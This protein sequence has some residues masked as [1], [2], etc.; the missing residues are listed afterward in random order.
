MARRHAWESSAGSVWSSEGSRETTL[1]QHYIEASSVSP[2]QRHPWELPLYAADDETRAAEHAERRQLSRLSVENKD[3]R[4]RLAS[5]HARVDELQAEV[6]RLREEARTRGLLLTQSVS[7]SRGDNNDGRKRTAEE[8]ALIHSLALEHKAEMQALQDES[9]ARHRKLTEMLAKENQDGHLDGLRTNIQLK[10]RLDELVERTNEQ[11]RLLQVSPRRNDGTGSKVSWSLPRDEGEAQRQTTALQYADEAS[12]KKAEKKRPSSSSSSSSDST[13]D[14]KKQAASELSYG[15]TEGG[16]VNRRPT[17][18]APVQVLTPAIAWHDKRGDA[19]GDPPRKIKA[20][21]KKKEKR[22][23]PSSSSSSPSPQSSPQHRAGEEQAPARGQV[24]TWHVPP[25]RRVSEEYHEIVIDY[26]NKASPTSKQQPT[27][28][29]YVEP[30]SVIDM[31]N[32]N[33]KKDKREEKKRDSS[34]SSSPSSSASSPSRATPSPRAGASE[35]VQIWHVPPP[36]RVSE[37][38]PEGAIAYGER[39]KTPKSEQTPTDAWYK[40]GNQEE[41]KKKK[42]NKEKKDKKEKKRSASSSS[43]SSSSSHRKTSSAGRVKAPPPGIPEPRV[44]AQRPTVVAAGHTFNS[45][46]RRDASDQKGAGRPGRAPEEPAHPSRKRDSSR[47][48]SSSSSSSSASSRRKLKG[49]AREKVPPGA[50]ALEQRPAVVAAG[51]TYKSAPLHDG[52]RPTTGCASEATGHP[53]HEQVLPPAVVLAGNRYKS[54]PRS[55]AEDAGPPSPGSPYASQR[56]EKRKSSLKPASTKFPVN[57]PTHGPAAPSREHVLTPK[58]PASS[59]SSSSSSS[60]SSRRRK[61]ASSGT[62]KTNE[63]TPAVGWHSSPVEGSVKGFRPHVL[64]TPAA[65]GAAAP[66]KKKGRTRASSASSS[67]S[68]SSSSSPPR[69]ASSTRPG[70]SVGIS[71]GGAKVGTTSKGDMPPAPFVQEENMHQYTTGQSQSFKKRESI[72]TDQSR[73]KKKKK[74]KKKDRKQSSSSSSSS[75]ASSSSSPLSPR[76]RDPSAPNGGR[77]ESRVPPTSDG[78]A[79]S[80]QMPELHSDGRGR[81]SEEGT[82]QWNGAWGGAE[83]ASA[84]PTDAHRKDWEDTGPVLHRESTPVWVA[85]RE[86]ENRADTPKKLSSSSSSSSSPSSTGKSNGGTKP[87]RAHKQRGAPNTTP[88]AQPPRAAQPQGY[89]RSGFSTPLPK[90]AV[91]PA[92][93]HGVRAEW[94]NKNS[95]PF[96]TH[97]SSSQ[98]TSTEVAQPRVPAEHRQSQYS[99]VGFGPSNNSPSPANDQT[100]FPWALADTGGKEKGVAHVLVPYVVTSHD[101]DLA[102][103]HAG[104]EQQPPTP[105]STPFHSRALGPGH[106]SESPSYGAHPARRRAAQTPVEPGR[107]GRRP[108]PDGRAAPRPITGAGLPELQLPHLTQYAA[109]DR[110]DAEDVAGRRNFSPI[111]STPPEPPL[112]SSSLLGPA[113][114]SSS[115]T[116]SGPA[117]RAG[118]Q[119]HHP[120]TT[121]SISPDG[122]FPVGS[123]H[124]TSPVMAGTRSVSNGF[125]YASGPTSRRSPPQVHFTQHD[126]P[127]V[128]RGYSG[129]KQMPQL[130]VRGTRV[131][132][133]AACWKWGDQDGGDGG[134][135]TVLSAGDGWATVQW[136]AGV[137][138]SYRCGD[139][140]FHDVLPVP[141]LSPKGRHGRSPSVRDPSQPPT[142]PGPNP[143]LGG[144][145]QSPTSATLY[146]KTPVMPAGRT[147]SSAL[148]SDKGVSEGAVY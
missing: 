19:A 67:S 15:P 115:I 6:A 140:G 62:A 132:R 54:P 1:L 36:R 68:S 26:G 43:S 75:S 109:S 77:Q 41:K 81:V 23:S 120:T 131:Q 147:F 97:P 61:S 38:Y 107:D 28:V 24:Q 89:Y 88:P 42:K 118:A 130:V 129:D 65:D 22:T 98:D 83:R 72:V 139:Q 71:G 37:K 114:R 102:T 84:P 87:A 45:A 93:G 148:A 7:P 78:P 51:Y 58:N 137:K 104:G 136:D 70:T 90:T 40:E 105:Q 144:R 74:Q 76:V 52:S 126:S 124:T 141:P 46:P 20:M 92:P 79:Q 59:A 17:A 14:K 35:Q 57:S 138:N 21:K 55:G 25:P 95:T 3:L 53:S 63:Q 34:S 91:A 49:A 44:L 13:N 50:G 39:S 69:R 121:R 128:T 135:G 101:V 56:Q 119:Q 133:N 31:E 9:D 99:T 47:S 145:S 18:D 85:P 112:R 110:R 117:P 29:R 122:Y 106:H 66:A 116:G 123:R 30:V 96:S 8:R 10:K 100:S 27:V 16:G 143:A 111:H 146:I 134:V 11:V 80:W 86:R 2:R 94:D 12:K 64:L 48:S 108:S 113:R 127:N 32:K 60:S 33:E 73:A 5:A 142:S 4:T 103:Q 82:P 125:Q